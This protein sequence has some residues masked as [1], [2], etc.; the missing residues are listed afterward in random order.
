MAINFKTDFRLMM[1]GGTGNYE[2]WTR[3]AGQLIKAVD[4]DRYTVLVPADSTQFINAMAKW[5]KALQDGV[6][7]AR[8]E[9]KNTKCKVRSQQMV[10]Q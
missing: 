10:L 4:G 8:A 6:N 5:F 1:R 9:V 2:R 3:K 7:K